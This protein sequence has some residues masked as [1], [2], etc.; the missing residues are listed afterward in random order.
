[1][2]FTQGSPLNVAIVGTGFAAKKRAE[3]L[4]ADPRANLVAVTGHTPSST[5][6]FCDTFGV[7][8]VDSCE[9]LMA[10]SEIDL[11]IICTV[12]QDHGAIAQAA[13]QAEKHVAVEYPLAL[14][15]TQAANLIQL[16]K[17][18]NRLLH[19]EHIE[20]LGGLH[21]TICQTLGE[22]GETFFVRYST[23]VPQHPVPRRWTYHHDLFGFPLSAAL[24]RIHRLTD[25]F[26]KVATVSCQTR[27]WDTSEGYYRSCLAQA[28]LKFQN[29]VIA[30]VTYG[31]GETFWQRERNFELH[32][33]QGSLIFV[34]DKGTLFKGEEAFPVEVEPR[35]GLF[36][37]ETS[38]LLDHLLNGKPL[39]VK[40]EA[41]LYAL[42]VAEAARQSVATGET[43]HL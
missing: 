10:R 36:A 8:A 42:Q 2:T 25:L 22:I 24:S 23:V 20:L 17:A 7:K 28:Q 37:K 3:A 26:G 14:D 13:L 9:G 16:A 15:P 4:Q 21:Q 30:E 27:F 6:A 41:S 18:Q 11:V 40:P 38:L 35:R 5:Q 32:G 19:V 12:N 43:V 1:M 33:D 39:Y 29:G 34:A 31:K